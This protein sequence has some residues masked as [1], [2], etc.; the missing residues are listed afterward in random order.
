MNPEF[1]RNVWLEL[2]TRRLITMTMVLLLIF[3]AAALTG[4]PMD[5]RP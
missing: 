3:F 2:T 5:N 4:M 1:R